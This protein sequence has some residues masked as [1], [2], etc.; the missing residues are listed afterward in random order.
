MGNSSSNT[1]LGRDIMLE[2]FFH[3]LEDGDE[4]VKSAMLAYNEDGL[5]ERPSSLEIKNLVDK[6]QMFAN[7]TQLRIV[8]IHAIDLQ[9]N[10]GA[11]VVCFNEEKLDERVDKVVKNS[12]G[13]TRKNGAAHPIKLEVEFEISSECSKNVAKN[14][15]KLFSHFG[16]FISDVEPHHR[17]MD[18]LRLIKSY[19]GSKAN[20][21]MKSQDVSYEGGRNAYN[22]YNDYNDT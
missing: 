19:D 9:T 10:I 2:F 16:L 15:A 11:S 12:P 7:N 17:N 8:E 6:F 22:G 21:T 18:L 4:M 13:T 5:G 20:V 3:Y 1:T 14:L